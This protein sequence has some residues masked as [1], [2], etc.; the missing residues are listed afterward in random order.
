MFR[1]GDWLSVAATCAP[2]SLNSRHIQHDDGAVTRLRF[3]GEGTSTI[4]RR[5]SQQPQSDVTLRAS[6]STFLLREADAIIADG[7]HDLAPDPLD[8]DGDQ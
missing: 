8:S 2:L 3:D 5:I 4:F 7:G 6:L 1:Q